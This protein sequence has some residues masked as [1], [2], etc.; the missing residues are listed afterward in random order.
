MTRNHHTTKNGKDFIV[1]APDENDAFKIIEYSRLLFA[2]TDQVLTVAEEFNMTV[3]KEKD[4]ISG[5]NNSQNSMVRI[6][7][8]NKGEI[9]G[10]LFFAGNSKLK[11]SHSGEF[12]LSVHPDWQGVGIGRTLIGALLDWAKANDK[13]EKI[14]LQV[15]ATNKNAIRLY[16]SLG[17]MEE[18]RHIKAIKQPTGEYIDVLQMYAWIK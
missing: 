8:S 4:W 15:F 11:A 17:F 10:L 3:E 14:S 2:S 7:E 9:I 6:A 16:R 13:I 1:R 5:F 12:G 18:G